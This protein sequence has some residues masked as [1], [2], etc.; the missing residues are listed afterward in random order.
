MK[1]NDLR[2]N[3]LYVGKAIWNR[4]RWEKDPETGKRVPRLRPQDDWIVVEHQ[5]LRIVSKDLWERVKARQPETAERGTLKSD[6]RGRGPK[7]LFS[8]LLK[9]GVCGS[10]YTV[11][12]SSYY[13]CSFHTNRGNTICSN[14]KVVR[15]DRIEGRL[16]QVIQQELF[17]PEAVAYLTQKVEEAVKELSQSR[18]TDRHGLGR[19][20]TQALRERDHVKN[21]IRQGLLGEITREMLE[22][23]EARVRDLEA[24]LQSVTSQETAI[25]TVLPRAIQTR[26]QSLDQI[27]GR[28]VE[29]A[30]GLLRDLLG[31][32]VHRP[33]SEGL[34]AEL[35]GNVEGLLRL[36]EALPRSYW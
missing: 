7:Y 29:Q 17:T 21:A 5:E 18:R 16:L 19:E 8:G 11:Y 1:Q 28:D 24:R 14:G 31:E 20:L 26:L 33:N 13:G 32:I 34:V 15:C 23:V 27:L 10:R 36:E 30:R 12:N 22:E 3:L 9:C 25:A 35:C 4:C 6:R 2:N